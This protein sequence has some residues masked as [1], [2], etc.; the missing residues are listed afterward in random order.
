MGEVY[1]AEQEEPVRRRVALKVIKHGMDTKQVVARFEAER[2]ALAMMDHPSVAKVFEA[3]A[4]PRGRPYFVMEFVRGVPITEHCDRQKLSVRKRLE[5]FLQVCEGVQHAHRNAI[6]HR[7]LKPSNVLVSIQDGR[8]APKIIDFGVA[9]ATTQKLTEKTMFTEL[10]VLIGTPEYMSPEQAEGTGQSVDTRTD[11]YSLGV[12]LYELLVGALPFD[13]S[14]LRSGGYEGIRKKIR[15]DEPPKPSRRL[16]TL[17][18]RSTE[19]ATCR[20][21]DLSGLQRRLRGDLDWITMRALEKD[22]TRRY[23]SPS[24]LAEDIRRHL[25]NEPVVASPPSTIYRA[26]KFVRRHRVGVGVT[27]LVMSLLAAFVVTTTIQSR[28][29]AREA[30]TSERVSEFLADMLGGVDPQMLGA[31]LWSDLRERVAEVRRGDGVSEQEIEAVLASL[32][33]ALVGVSATDAALRL[34]DEQILARAARTIDEELG[35]EPWIAGRLEHT[36]GSTYRRLGLLKQAERYSLRAIETRRQLLGRDHPETLRSMYMLAQTYRWQGRYDEAAELI[37]E[38]L[39]A[40]RRVL[41]KD[42]PDT[43]GS[44]G[45]LARSHLARDLLAE[46]EEQFS[47]AL[48]AQG[49]VLGRE[50]PDTLRSREGLGSTYRWQGRY[51]E[52][53]KLQRQTLEIR[54]RVLGPDHIQTARSMEHLGQACGG[55]GRFEEAAELYRETLEIRRQ[56]LGTDHLGT[57]S[58]MNSLAIA[59]AKLRRYEVAEELFREAFEIQRRVLGPDHP[60]TLDYMSALAAQLKNQHRYDEAAELLRHVLGVRRRMLGAEHPDTLAAMDGLA[61]CHLKSQRLD[62]AEVLYGKVVEERLRI[63]GDD[64]AETQRIMGNLGAVYDKIERYD[65]AEKLWVQVMESRKRHLGQGDP[66]TISA[67]NRLAGFYKRR[68]ST[69]EAR[70]IAVELLS[71]RKA[72]AEAPESDSSARNNYAWALLTCEPAELQDPEEALKFALEANEL[73]GFRKANHLDTLALAYHRTGRNAEAVDTQKK[74]I[75]RLPAGDD[76]LSEYEERLHEF[77]AEN[78]P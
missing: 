69:D 22:R 20:A 12:M 48:E 37:V 3:G 43:L 54:R 5:L 19:S 72:A 27:V 66:K 56:A 59:N 36:L 30:E 38:T 39:E 23:G 42:H 25:K 73:G 65:D 9:K 46:A 21:V 55:Q 58:A 63:F 8:A 67:L 6:I 16:S 26:R 10:G 45:E 75:K 62:E 50:H 41:G 31:A 77:E 53:E 32:D 44:M 11:V 64:D 17:G 49:R 4:T 51:D 57:L 24:D 33:D 34:L 74:A 76:Q 14:E 35:D 1:E 2:Q 71:S 18:D 13:P 78:S 60:D 29:I 70:S 68:G 47:Q 52:A 7:D 15:E 28:R 61:W 40:Q